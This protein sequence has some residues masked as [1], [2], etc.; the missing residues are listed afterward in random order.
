MDNRLTEDKPK[1]SFT[2]SKIFRE[3]FPQYLAIG[4]SAEEFWDGDSWLVK[5]YREAYRIRVENEEKVADRNAWRIGEYIRFAL[6]SVPITVNGFAPKGHHMQ[7]YPEKPFAM[8]AEEQKR[9][10]TRKKQEANKQEMAQAVFHAFV[11]KMNKNILKR[12]EREK[13]ESAKQ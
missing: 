7:K 11:D 4:M 12:L 6:A 9:E 5:A 3:A 13:A 8:Q 1:E 2:I 10:D